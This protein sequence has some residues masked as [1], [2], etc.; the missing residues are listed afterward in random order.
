[1]RY[2]LTSEQMKTCDSTEIEH[3]G[4]PSIVLMERAALSVRDVILHRYAQ[5]SNILVICGSGNNGGDGFAVA[6]LL[7]MAGRR[8]DVLFVGKHD[9]MTQETAKQAE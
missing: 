6:R 7:N 1:M 8:A 2:L 5:A 4:V 3:Y 9:H